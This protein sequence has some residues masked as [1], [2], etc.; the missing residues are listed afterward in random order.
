MPKPRVPIDD[1]I[2]GARSALDLLEV[3]DDALAEVETTAG[4]MRRWRVQVRKLKNCSPAM[5]PWHRWRRDALAERLRERLGLGPLDPIPE[6][7]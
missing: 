3:A 2:R 6:P 4:I 7:K 1:I 5:R